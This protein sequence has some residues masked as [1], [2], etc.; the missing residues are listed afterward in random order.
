MTAPVVS[1]VVPNYNHARFLR[2]RIESILA[3]TFQDFEIILLDD[4]STDESVAIL[5]SYAEHPKVSQL[6]VNERNTGSP[7]TQWSRGIALAAGSFVWI[8]ESDDLADPALLE[9]LVARLRDEPN[10]VLAYCHSESIDEHGKTLCEPAAAG[11]STASPPETNYT[12]PGRAVLLERLRHYNS[13]PNASA[14]VFRK[15]EA[16]ATEMSVGFRFC[17]D[18]LFW[19]RLAA[20]GD[21]AYSA[22][23]LNY[24]R[25]H[26]RTTRAAYDMQSR[27]L[28]AGEFL[29]VIHHIHAVLLANT[30][31]PSLR[32]AWIFSDWRYADASVPWFILADNEIPW[33]LRWAFFSRASRWQA[34][35]ILK[36]AA[37]RVPC[38]LQAYKW[39]KR[40]GKVMTW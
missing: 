12:A 1:V 29:R 35:W 6:V 36:R 20:R 32:D 28:R 40:A 3:Q 24:F 14:V 8:A 5:Q 37:S 21:I 15:S 25:S 7:C 11:N 2:K 10:T 13:I 22:D 30:V 34:W 33:D 4:G 38:M 26:S 9:V 17:G 27:R 19:A 18:W 23:S 31:A 16:A 39:L